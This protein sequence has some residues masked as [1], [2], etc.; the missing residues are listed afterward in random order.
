MIKKELVIF[1]IDHTLAHNDADPADAPHYDYDHEDFDWDQWQPSY[2][3]P[4]KDDVVKVLEM[5]LLDVNVHVALLTARDERHRI[6]T[7]DWLAKHDINYHSLT[8]RIVG[9]NT[10]PS[11]DLKLQHIIEWELQGYKIIGMYDDHKG[12]C[13]AARAYGVTVFQITKGEH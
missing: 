5:Y 8:M 1:D 12:V 9:D 7:E 3:M 4:R 11:A 2:T 6:P 10:K 13:D